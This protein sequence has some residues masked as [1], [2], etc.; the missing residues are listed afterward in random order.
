VPREGRVS[1][2]MSA[3]CRNICGPLKSY[4]G[5]FL[6]SFRERVRGFNDLEV[7]LTVHI[8]LTLSCRLPDD[9]IHVSE[10]GGEDAGVVLGASS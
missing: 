10:F 3:V 4:E 1:S 9:A 5:G 6:Q 8:E 2:V 7:I